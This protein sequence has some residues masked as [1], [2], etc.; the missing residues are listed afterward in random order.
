[1]AA[2]IV[3]SAPIWKALAMGMYREWPTRF[4]WLGIGI[5]LAGVLAGLLLVIW[6][7]LR[8]GHAA[9]RPAG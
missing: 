9:L 6:A 2:I 7:E 5:G 4:E 8:A 1:M 3:A